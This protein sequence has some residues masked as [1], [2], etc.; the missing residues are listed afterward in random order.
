MV[1]LMMIDAIASVLHCEV[2]REV[3]GK[4]SVE[5]VVVKDVS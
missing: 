1:R 3:G 2:D 4:T 5:K